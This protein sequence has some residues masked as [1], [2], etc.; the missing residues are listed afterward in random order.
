MQGVQAS[1]GTS[2]GGSSK[3]RPED[4]LFVDAANILEVNGGSMTQVLFFKALTGEGYNQAQASRLL[5]AD[6]RFSFCGMDVWL[7]QGEAAN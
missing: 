7:V 2:S 5:R 6:A 1:S 4:Q 3:P